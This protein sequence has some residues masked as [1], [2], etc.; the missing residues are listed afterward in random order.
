MAG[1][2]RNAEPAV[3]DQQLRHFQVL[4]PGITGQL[5]AQLDMAISRK[6]ATENAAQHQLGSAFDAGAF[7]L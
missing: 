1:T 3:V 6:R 4:E 2:K 5:F 7:V